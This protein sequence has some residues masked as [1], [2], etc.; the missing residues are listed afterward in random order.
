MVAAGAAQASRFTLDAARAS[1]RSA[2]GEAL[3]LA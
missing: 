3:S 2:I 1:F